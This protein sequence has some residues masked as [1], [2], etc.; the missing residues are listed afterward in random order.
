[1][2]LSDLIIW[3]VGEEKQEIRAVKNMRFQLSAV[4]WRDR[5]LHD[6]G[7]VSEAF[8]MPQRAAVQLTAKK[9]KRIKRWTFHIAGKLNDNS[10]ISVK[11]LPE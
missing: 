1:M 8:V 11:T 6:L 9:W 3:Q 2:S 5:K 10:N 7:C 4:F